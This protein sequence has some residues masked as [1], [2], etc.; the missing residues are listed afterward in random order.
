LGVEAPL[1]G[2]PAQLAVLLE[3]RPAPPQVRQ[4]VRRW[5]SQADRLAAAPGAARRGAVVRFAAAV[6]ASS[7]AAPRCGAESL[8][9]RS[10]PAPAF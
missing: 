6:S 5:V 3:S 9:E 1:A 10:D 8:E 2:L 4:D 7:D